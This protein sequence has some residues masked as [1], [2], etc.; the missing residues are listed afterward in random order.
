VTVKIGSYSKTRAKYILFIKRLELLFVSFSGFCPKKTIVTVFLWSR[1]P[2][3]GTTP[4]PGFGI[5]KTTGIAN[6]I[7]VR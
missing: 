6:T 1:N 5:G 3:I 2:G 4:I 7:K